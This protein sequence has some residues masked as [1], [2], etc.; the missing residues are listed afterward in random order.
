MNYAYLRVSSEKQDTED[1]V[2]IDEQRNDIEKLA[3]KDGEMIDVWLC[4]SKRFRAAN[5]RMVEPSGKRTDR[6]D[7][8]RLIEDIRNGK[9]TKV[10][11]WKLDR[12]GRTSPPI[13]MLRDAVLKAKIEIRLVIGAWD[14]RTAELLGAVGGLELLDIQSR[15]SSGRHGR[16][17]KKG[18]AHGAPKWG[19]EIIRDIDGN[20]VGYHLTETGRA[21]LLDIG[22]RILSGE[23]Y[24]KISCEVKRPD[25]GYWTDSWVK[26]VATN[27]FYRGYVT[28]NN[29]IRKG[30]HE[31]VFDAE[32]AR[33]LKR[34]VER[35]WVQDKSRPRNKGT[36]HLFAGLLRCGHC[37]GWMKVNIQ[38]RGFKKYVGYLCGRRYR[39]QK[40]HPPNYIMESVLVLRLREFL[41]HRDITDLAKMFDG[42]P[43]LPYRNE[44]LIQ[45]R[46]HAAELEQALETVKAI[47][48]AAKLIQ[49]DLER[50]RADIAVADVEPDNGPEID[51]AILLQDL[52]ELQGA[53]WWE[54]DRAEAVALLR[55][56]IRELWIKDGRIIPPPFIA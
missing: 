47:P 38:S 54:I 3:A 7:F 1:K 55:T 25:G 27:A 14:A 49:A 23:S 20:S 51:K 10:Y 18:L 36:I 39:T 15:L 4:D 24:Y 19:Y 50:V 33:R 35:R 44:R 9:C 16:F 8:V 6:P 34:E 53:K 12:L 42:K 2:S 56:A 11:A 31:P 5:G 37:G 13:V 30:T 41:E 52:Q 43:A 46:E 28:L 17:Q 22:N 32:T 21:K 45:L 29:E 40:D 26:N 48:S